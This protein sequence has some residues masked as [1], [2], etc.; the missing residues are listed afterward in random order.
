[1]LNK[2][3]LRLVLIVLFILLIPLQSLAKNSSDHTIELIDSNSNEVIYSFSMAHYHL[4]VDI[5]LFQQDIQRWMEKNK[6]KFYQTMVLDSI[7]K[8]GNIIKGKP[9]I[10]LDEQSLLERIVSKFFSGG[11][12]DIPLKSIESNYDP[13]EVPQLHE[14]TLASYTSFFHNV[15]S[16]RSVNIEI[17]AAAIHQVIVGSGDI[18]SFNTI[19]GPRDVASGY[20]EAPEI[21]Y[22]KVVRGIGGGV[23]QTSSTLFNAVDQLAVDILERHHHSK[24]VGYVPKGRD[25]TVAFGGLDFQFQNT[26]GIPFLIKTYY[27][28]GAITIVITTSKEY[29]DIYKHELNT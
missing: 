15:N 6:Q 26:T 25:A 8:E 11:T 21:V 3:L 13:E 7:D 20:Q 23:C 16:G 17:S 29:A 2:K 24:D 4:D 22:G 10:T 28:P 27:H 14:V 18:F 5:E 1:M 12:V 9:M 19:V